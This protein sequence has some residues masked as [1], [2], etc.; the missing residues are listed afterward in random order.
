[1]FAGDSNVSPFRIQNDNQSSLAGMKGQLV[2]HCDAVWAESFITGRLNFDRGHEIGHLVDDSQAKVSDDLKI[3]PLW[4]PVAYWVNPD[5]Q[6]STGA[7]NRG[8]KQCW[9]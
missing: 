1:M 9:F 8:F 6:R 7:A 4:Q 5:T 3:I 2:P